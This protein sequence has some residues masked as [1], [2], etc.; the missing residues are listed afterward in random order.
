MKE[1]YILLML[2]FSRSEIFSIFLIFF[3]VY[4][5]SFDEDRLEDEILS[6]L[7]SVIVPI[8]CFHLLIIKF[9]DVRY[10]LGAS[11]NAFY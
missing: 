1:N 4:I 10:N 3:N 5:Q 9:S 7:L 6:V 11:S 8:H 2:P